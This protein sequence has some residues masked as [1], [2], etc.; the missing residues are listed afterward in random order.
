MFV[1]ADILD[2]SDLKEFNYEHYLMEEVKL[3]GIVDNPATSL[4]RVP[5]HCFH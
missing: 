1:Y 5:T 2:D 3:R 4:V